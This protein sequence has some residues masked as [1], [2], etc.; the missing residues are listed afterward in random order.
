[1]NDN[2]VHTTNDGGGTQCQNHKPPFFQCCCNCK[3]HVAVHYHCC[4]DPKPS[5]L[6]AIAEGAA[7]PCICNIRKGWACVV[8]NGVIYDN[9]REHSMGC[10]EHTEVKPN[11]VGNQ[12]REACYALNIDHHGVVINDQHQ[13]L[14]EQQTQI[15][16][17]VAANYP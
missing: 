17:Y 13:F 9:W 2:P 12:I 4:T 7:R 15:D 16:A 3:Y 5:P 1:M 6:P 8:R 14:P 10:E 11:V